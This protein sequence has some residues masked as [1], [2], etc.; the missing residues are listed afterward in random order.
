MKEQILRKKYAVPALAVAVVFVLS[1]CT[2]LLS[3]PEMRARA[4]ED[5]AERI[6]GALSTLDTHALE[7]LVCE[8]PWRV[9][10]PKDD[11]RPPQPLTVEVWRIEPLSLEDSN[12][13]DPDPDAEFFTVS[14]MDR[15]DA[16]EFADRVR[17]DAVVRV[18]EQSAC[19]WALDA[20]FVVYLGL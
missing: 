19:L 6:A 14:F 4:V 2:P 16:Q 15:I 17:L 18:D 12:H 7:G 5:E 11:P 20:P 10:T 3:S 8:E 9:Q 13:Q 1:G